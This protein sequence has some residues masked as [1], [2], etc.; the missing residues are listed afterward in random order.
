MIEM[1]N[2]QPRVGTN[3]RGAGEAAGK[4]LIFI[5]VCTCVDWND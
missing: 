1:H 3:K 5:H 2:I 4:V